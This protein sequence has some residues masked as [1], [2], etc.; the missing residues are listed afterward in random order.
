MGGAPGP[1][2]GGAR[3]AWRAFHDEFLSFGGP[4]IPLVRE[5]MLGGAAG[6]LF[7]TGGPR[8]VP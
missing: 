7:S 6:A 1:A 4:P 2:A 3:D 8:N 5:A